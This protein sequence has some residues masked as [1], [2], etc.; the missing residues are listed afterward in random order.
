MLL[1]LVRH[2][3]TVENATHKIQGQGGGHL[4]K[5]GQR[6]IALLARQLKN[7]K[8]DAIYSSDLQRSIDTAVAVRQYHQQTPLVYSSALREFDFGIFQG[9]PIQAVQSAAKLG[10][11]IQLR[12][13]GME[14][15]RDVRKR[16]IKFTNNVFDQYP[17]GRVL[18]VTHGGPIAIISSIIED[19][20][21]S[22]FGMGTD[23]P[24]CSI[25][26]YEI[27]QKL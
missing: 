4:S 3:E 13:P 20:P 15:N 17:Q 22:S 26:T 18:F 7:E 9:L 24:N 27:S 12:P 10:N 5:L 1:L 16:L 14:S 19:K 2:G 21:L 11:H 23:V 25:Q 6:Q 8:F